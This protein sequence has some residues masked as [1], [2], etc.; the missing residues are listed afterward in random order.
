MQA[1]NRKG[2]KEEIIEVAA[3]GMPVTE[4]AEKIACTPADVRVLFMWFLCG[5]CVVFRQDFF[6]MQL[7]MHAYVLL[8]PFVEH[9]K[10]VVPIQ[11][12]CWRLR[13][14]VQKELAN[15]LIEK[16][17]MLTILPCSSARLRL[18]P[19]IDRQDS[20]YARNDGERQ[21]NAG[22]AHRQDRM[23]GQGT[24]FYRRSLLTINIL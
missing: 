22:P 7:F 15:F 9:K 17:K 20:L 6:C 23:R 8:F 3:G 19:P 13:N 14:C 10:C 24:P 5:F 11:E 12:M 18:H 4:L 21:P 16:K 1:G 2:D